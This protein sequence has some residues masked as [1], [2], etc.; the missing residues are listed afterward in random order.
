M[1]AVVNSRLKVVKP[2]IPKE[3]SKYSTSS[4]FKS[5]VGIRSV[6]TAKDICS[7]VPK[8]CILYT[9]SWYWLRKK[10]S[11]FYR[12]RCACAG[13]TAVGDNIVLWSR[14]RASKKMPVQSPRPRTAAM[15]RSS[16]LEFLDESL[17]SW[18]RHFFLW[19][20]LEYDN[21]LSRH[22]RLLP[23]PCRSVMVEPIM[24]VQIVLPVGSSLFS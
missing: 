23:L 8:N 1:Q 20:S 13:A 21:P 7:A 16:N 2:L 17:V 3:V 15:H 6:L 19:G 18:N 11:Q 9:M 10:K 14:R 24:S 4:R 12:L 22:S 5:L